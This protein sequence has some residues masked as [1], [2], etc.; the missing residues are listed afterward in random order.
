MTTFLQLGCIF[1]AGV[2]AYSA[3]RSWRHDK[4]GSI[5]MFI[6]VA[7]LGGILWSTL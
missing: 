5:L 1:G 6:V 2:F 4:V 3:S 7:G